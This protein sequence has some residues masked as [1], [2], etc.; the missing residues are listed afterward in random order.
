MFVIY[1]ALAFVLIL[2]ESTFLSFPAVLLSIAFLSLI[3]HD[4]KK[5]FFASF[6]IGIFYDLL[7][8]GLLGKTS[9]VFLVV[10]LA[11]YLYR[12]KFVHTHLIFEIIFFSFLYKLW[13]VVA[14]QDF[15]LMKWLLIVF[16]GV[17]AIFWAKKMGLA[18]KKEDGLLIGQ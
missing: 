12:K 11:A 6:L 15:S 4:F 7:S 17:L 8:G 13:Q 3:S 1:V 5:V 9:L 14:G 18:E 16:L 2:F 10:S